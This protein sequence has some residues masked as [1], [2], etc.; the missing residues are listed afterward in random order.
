MVAKNQIFVMRLGDEGTIRIATPEQQRE[1][2]LGEGDPVVEIRRV[3][4]TVELYVGPE[5][6]FVVEQP[7][8]RQSQLRRRRRTRD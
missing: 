3:D 6:G 7:T 5:T 1:Y 4:G 2:G 8:V